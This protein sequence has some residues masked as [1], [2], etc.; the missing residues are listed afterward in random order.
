MRSH[1]IPKRVGDLDWSR[2]P[3]LAIDNLCWT[4]EIDI[5]A[6]AQIC[7][8]EKALYLRLAARESAIRAQHTGPLGMP[9]EDSCLEFFFSPM[10]GD[11]R[12][13]NFEFNANKCLFLGLGSRIEDLVRIIPDE[14]PIEEL[15]RPETVVS[16]TG[17]EISYQIPYAFVRRFFPGF[18]PAS[19]KTMRA[20]CF[21]CADN[22][23]PPHYLCWSPVVTRPEPRTFHWPY[24]FGQMIFE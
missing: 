18:A 17:F 22:T 1:V 21:T 2:V 14:E 7:Y 6:T 13:L 10:E 16:E 8:D 23:E 4:E 11:V 9:C 20:N 3:V 24:D 15:F 12:Y 19:G 5:S